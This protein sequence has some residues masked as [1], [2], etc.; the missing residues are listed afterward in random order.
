MKDMKDEFTTV[1]ESRR[2]KLNFWRENGVNPYENRY[3]PTHTSAQL[4]EMFEQK[5][6]EELQSVEEEFAIAGRLMQIR[7]IGKLMFARLRD[8]D[9][10]IQVAFEKSTLG[11]DRYKL[12]KKFDV[13]DIVWV[14]GTIFK[15]RTGELTVMSKDFAL[16]TKNLRP[17]PE[18]YHG[19]KDVE[20]RYRQRYVDLIMNPEVVQ[21]FRRRAAIVRYIRRFLEDLDFLEVE[22]PMMHPI[23][24]GANARPFITHHNALDIDLYLRI[25]PELYLKRLLVGGLERVYEINRNFRNEGV[26]TQHNPEFTMLEFY[27]AYA[28]YE[29]LMELSEKMLSGLVKEI[30]GSY[31]VE[32][33]E[34]KIDFTPP[35]R[36]L[37]VREA[38][39]EYGAEY[40]IDESVLSSTDSMR[41]LL[42]DKF[43]VQVEDFWGEGKLLME[44]FEAVAEEKLINPTFVIEF[45]LEVSPLSR[46]NDENPNLVD[47]FE[48]MVGGMELANA[49]SELNDPED[50]RGRFEKQLEAKEAG[51]SEAHEMDEDFI[52]ALEYGMPPAAG[53]GIGIDRLTMLLTGKTSIREV[54]LFPLLKPLPKK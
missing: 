50:Q 45:P 22:T 46:R 43:E 29:D 10:D 5:D 3:K 23:A 2:N 19:L 11:N 6:A 4:R 26:D 31:V 9:G 38:V 21:I 18:K 1:E 40:G 33:G 39:L 15:T 47:R 16:L 35:W 48:L 51:D 34:H 36:R 52:T 20:M 53:E 32:W 41:R 13:G 49:F 44:L 14:K 24:G 7:I 12:A 28:T 8:R 17:L 30:N 54:I 25:A 37:P 27:W 42:K